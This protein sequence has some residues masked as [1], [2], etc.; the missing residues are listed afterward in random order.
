M[1]E[2]LAEG[3][4]GKDDESMIGAELMRYGAT[5]ATESGFAHYVAALLADRL[6]ETPRPPGYVPCTTWWWVDGADYLGRAAL[7]HEL[8]ERLLNKGG[9]VGYDV[10]PRARRR[11]HATAML[12]AVLPQAAALGIDPVLVTCDTDNIGSRKAIEA[13]GGELEDERG[14]KLR[15]WVPTRLNAS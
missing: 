13:N 4:G 12:R 15:F 7:R 5:W 14:G 6:P 9:H 3:R 8:T 11:R 10:R 1:A 2:F